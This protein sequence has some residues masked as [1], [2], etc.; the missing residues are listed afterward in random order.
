M[1][2]L[3]QEMRNRLVR[4]HYGSHGSLY[5]ATNAGYQGDYNNEMTIGAIS[6]SS[7]HH[8]IL[9]SLFEQ[10]DR[11]ILNSIVGQMLFYNYW[12]ICFNV[13]DNS[14]LLIKEEETIRE[15]D[16]EDVEAERNEVEEIIQGDERESWDSKLTFLLATIGYAVGLGNVWR[17]PYLAQ[18]NG[19]GAFL[20]P[21]FIML[22][23]QG[24]PIFFLEV[25]LQILLVEGGGDRQHKWYDFLKAWIFDKS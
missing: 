12:N 20:V 7:G 21:Y 10:P 4:N 8:P 23:V 13:Y 17:F 11:W 22:F 16:E 1:L 25:G 5:G 2:T 19:G 3:L 24:I 6:A 18:K 9:S 15:E 14:N